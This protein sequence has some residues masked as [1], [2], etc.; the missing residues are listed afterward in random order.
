M[1]NRFSCFLSLAAYAV[2]VVYIYL[3]F[4]HNQVELHRTT[5]RSFAKLEALPFRRTLSRC[6]TICGGT[7]ARAFAVAWLSECLG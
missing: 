4:F 7:F 3:H 5:D 1:P 6:C 2:S